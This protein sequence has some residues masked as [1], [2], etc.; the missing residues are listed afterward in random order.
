MT[1]MGLG[2]G[3][4]CQAWRGMPLIRY[5]TGDVSR[6]VTGP[7]PCGTRL[8]TLE[9]IT[10]RW[11]GCIPIGPHYLTMADL[12]EAL[13]AVDGVLN[14][15]A[16]MTNENGR[17]RLQLEVKIAEDR[18][19]I[20]VIQAVMAVVPYTP[21]FDLRVSSVNAIPS[22]MAKRTLIDRRNHS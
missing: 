2:G 20:P 19:T 22:S 13:F 3:G 12:D 17:D 4:E 18:R 7:C 1:E 15:T 11:N 9:H 14:F 16:T 21:Y 10:H 5:R 8:K 6:F